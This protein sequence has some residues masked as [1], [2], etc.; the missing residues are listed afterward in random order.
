MKMQGSHSWIEVS[1]L[2]VLIQMNRRKLIPGMWKASFPIRYSRTRSI[3]ISWRAIV[4][5]HT[6]YRLA[7][8]LM[9]LNG[10]MLKD[11]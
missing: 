6:I 7:E 8:S 5:S 3:G 2:D 11:R 10:R 4:H 9:S 1:F